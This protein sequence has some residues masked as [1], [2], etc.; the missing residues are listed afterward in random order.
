MAMESA[1]GLGQAARSVVRCG[2]LGTRAG[3][4]GAVHCERASDRTSL[5]A[6]LVT[7]EGGF[8]PTFGQFSTIPRLGDRAQQLS[9]WFLW[10]GCWLG[11]RRASRRSGPAVT[12]EEAA[13]LQRRG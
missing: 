3:D 13:V 12:V 1:G 6:L 11:E 8:S 9:F 4:T 7:C 2:M 10:L 5:A